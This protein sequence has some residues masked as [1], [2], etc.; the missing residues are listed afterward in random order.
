M[1]SRLTL[2]L[3]AATLAAVL[4]APPA[5]SDTRPA[6]P[7]DSASRLSRLI[8]GAQQ[9]P[10]ASHRRAITIAACSPQGEGCSNTN[11]CCSGQC[12]HDACQ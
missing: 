2:V 8:H 3:A 5:I 1:S 11:D 4:S 10:P 9:A 7:S 6:V 12:D